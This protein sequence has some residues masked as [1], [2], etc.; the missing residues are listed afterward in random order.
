MQSNSESSYYR[1]RLPG[2]SISLDITM[3]CIL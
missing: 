1:H 2:D 3:G